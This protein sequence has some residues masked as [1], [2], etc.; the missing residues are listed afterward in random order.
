MNNIYKNLTFIPFP[1]ETYNFLVEQFN[2]DKQ[3]DKILVLIIDYISKNKQS[4]TSDC[5]YK[6]FLNNGTELNM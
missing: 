6:F 2:L 3:N 5:D 1:E 4:A